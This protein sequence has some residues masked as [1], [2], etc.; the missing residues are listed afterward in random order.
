M[1][2]EITAHD[3]GGHGASGWSQVAHSRSEPSTGGWSKAANFEKE[4]QV[5]ETQANEEIPPN[6]KK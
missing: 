2:S 3:A 1:M 4:V 6:R 5:K